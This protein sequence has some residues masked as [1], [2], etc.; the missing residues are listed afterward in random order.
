MVKEADDTMK[1][2]IIIASGNTFLQCA[3]VQS[4]SNEEKEDIKVLL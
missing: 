4:I 3:L 2:I 1:I